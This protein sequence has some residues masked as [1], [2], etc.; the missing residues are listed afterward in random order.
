[1][2]PCRKHIS[3]AECYTPPPPNVHCR[4]PKKLAT[5]TGV[6]ETEPGPDL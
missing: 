2:G 1:M 4:Y 6:W 5:L 3:V